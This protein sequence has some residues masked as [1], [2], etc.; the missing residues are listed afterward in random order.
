MRKILIYILIISLP[1]CTK[2][3]ALNPIEGKW[4]LVEMQDDIRG[5]H[6]N[7]P[8]CYIDFKKDGRFLIH[9]NGVYNYF[10]TA[11]NGF[12]RYTLQQ[13][14]SIRFYNSSSGESTSCF[15]R[16]R[17]GLIISYGRCGERFSYKY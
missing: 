9:P 5:Q 4:M 11:L 14:D 3:N 17:N 6:L 8:D 7:D 2:D 13:N 15:Y 16:Y 10:S 12:D 1:A